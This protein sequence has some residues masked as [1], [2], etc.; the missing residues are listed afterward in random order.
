MNCNKAK[1]L[2]ILFWEQSQTCQE[3]LNLHWQN[4]PECGASFQNLAKAIELCRQNLPSEERL[5]DFSHYWSRVSKRLVKPSWSERWGQRIKSVVTLVNR[6]IWGPVPAYAVAAVL[7]LIA[8]AVFPLSKGTK[9]ITL[10]ALQTKYNLVVGQ[11]ELVSAT[12]RGGLT[13]Y[14]LAHNTTPR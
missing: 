12:A 13:V 8:A 14:A 2:E 6:S 3:E 4:C 7:I 9:S 5:E 10:Q 11:H 1:K